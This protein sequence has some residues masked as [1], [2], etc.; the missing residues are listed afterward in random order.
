M[1]VSELFRV[2]ARAV[3]ATAKRAEFLVLHVMKGHHC[4]MDKQIDP[5]DQFSEAETVRR[6]EAALKRML[7][8]PPKRHNESG[9][10]RKA[11]KAKGRGRVKNRSASCLPHPS[12]CARPASHRSRQLFAGVLPEIKLGA[13]TAITIH[14]PAERVL[15]DRNV[16]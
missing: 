14:F 15:A 12:G 16:A 1:L 6:R 3:N 11:S 13:G 9:P 2:I 8:T 7:S 10:K 4:T 5:S